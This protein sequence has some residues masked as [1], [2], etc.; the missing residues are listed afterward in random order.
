MTRD[1]ILT[2]ETFVNSLYLAMGFGLYNYDPLYYPFIFIYF[3]FLH[4]KRYYTDLGEEKG[5]PHFS[6]KQYER[7]SE[8][9]T[10]FQYFKFGCN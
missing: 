9:Q 5:S 3:Q 10:L 4:E 2:V 1:L 7:K 6:E 8:N